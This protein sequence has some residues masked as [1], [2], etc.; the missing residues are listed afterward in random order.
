MKISVVT[1]CYNAEDSIEKTLNSVLC[2]TYPDIELIVIDGGSV[3]STPGIIEKYRDNIR[4]LVSEKDRGIYDAM[5]KGISHAGGDLLIF[6]NSGD[7]F[8]SP[9]T[10]EKA[11]CSMKNS[12][13]MLFY[14]DINVIE[15]NGVNWVKTF[16]D[17]DKITLTSNCLCH[18]A[19]F[20]RKELFQ[21]IGNYD[22]NYPI[23]ADHELNLRALI[24]YN[25]RAQ[26]IPVI[27]CN[28]TMGGYSTS[29]KNIKNTSLEVRRIAL[30]HYG[31][32]RCKLLR[33]IIYT[34]RNISGRK[35]KTVL[36]RVITG[37]LGLNL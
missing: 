5:N 13:A 34:L 24:K 11:V 12:K 32:F 8:Y 10:L 17:T 21:K 35:V 20:Y 1:V 36:R 15:E 18:Q 26:Y 2:Q 3:D 4:V 16:R 27:V 23:C 30:I 22:E 14:G 6:M 31:K 7:C 25:L 33:L 28:F 37:I 19:V 29:R 9:E